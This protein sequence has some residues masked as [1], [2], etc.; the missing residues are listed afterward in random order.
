MCVWPSLPR[1]APPLSPAGARRSSRPPW[2]PSAG[3]LMAVV[4]PPPLLSAEAMA[5]A[6]SLPRANLAFLADIHAGTLASVLVT[7]FAQAISVNLIFSVLAFM[8]KDYLPDAPDDVV[9]ERAGVLAALYF[10]GMTISNPLWGRVSERIGRKPCLFVGNLTATVAALAIGVSNSYAL[11]CAIRLVAGLLNPVT[12]IVKTVIA[13]IDPQKKHSARLMSCLSLSFNLGMVVGPSV[14][15]ILAFPCGP[16]GEER[17]T[18]ICAVSLLRNHPFLLPFLFMAFFNA[19]A[20]VLQCCYLPETL[21]HQAA[22]APPPAADEAHDAKDAEDDS[23]VELE[24][25]PLMSRTKSQSGDEEGAT[26]TTRSDSRVPWTSSRGFL[27]PPPSRAPPSKPTATVD[28][29]SRRI[30]APVASYGLLALAFTLMDESFPLMCS[31]SLESGGL[32]MLSGAV[33][34]VLATG[35]V[36]TLGYTFFGYPASVRRFGRLRTFRWGLLGT[37]ISAAMLPFPTLFVGGRGGGELRSVPDAILWPIL[38]L[39]M[40]IKNVA[41]VAAFTTSAIV[42]NHAAPPGCLSRVNGIAQSIASFARAAGPAI[43]GGAWSLAIKAQAFAPGVAQFIP[44]GSYFVLGLVAWRVCS[45][46]PADL[47][48][49]S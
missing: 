5:L 34:A 2:V 31:A 21:D 10:L 40:A 33:G 12:A 30:A 19:L 16:R 11:T 39:N 47:D 32:S 48:D 23:D 24:M 6:P 9:A 22:R 1:L 15:G 49:Y 14:G 7:Q 46:I 18:G 36:S 25:A 8:V 27:V 26:T 35:A 4:A 43:A 37:A 13:E 41:G 38:V 20:I 44:F 29:R 3:L 17:E 45:Q 28:F 42:I